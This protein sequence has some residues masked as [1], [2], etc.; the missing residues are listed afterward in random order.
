MVGGQPGEHTEQ[1]REEAT[2][3]HDSIV[4]RVRT[5]VNHGTP[6]PVGGL[7]RV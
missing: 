3:E 7:A 5:P 4:A 2:M 1:R 6:A